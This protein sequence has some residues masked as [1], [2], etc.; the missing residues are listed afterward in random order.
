MNKKKLNLDIKI[1]LLAMLLLFACLQ[2]MVI[3]GT[4]INPP[5]RIY[6]LF[7]ENPENPQ[8]L[9]CK[10]AVE[11]GGTEPLLAWSGVSR[12]IKKNI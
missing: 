12:E 5:S 7:L 3:A 9:A 8:S 1:V 11:K 2:Q 4:V 10:A 6:K